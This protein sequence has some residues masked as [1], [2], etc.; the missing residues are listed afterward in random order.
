M[1]AEVCPFGLWPA[2]VGWCAGGDAAGG[3]RRLEPVGRHQR[4]HAAAV[5]V[6]APRHDA[7]VWPGLRRREAQRPSAPPCGP[8]PPCRARDPRF[9]LC[10]CAAAPHCSRVSRR[11]RL[12]LCPAHPRGQRAPVR[13]S[14][15][16]LPAVG[17]AL[18]VHLIDIEIHQWYG[19]IV[20][21]LVCLLATAGRRCWSEAHA[22]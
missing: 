8:L 22:E 17:S 18:R 13:L 5:Q 12:A 9:V 10:C 19:G 15:N 3:L 14:S 7:H 4:P 6:P 16:V 21:S 11:C 1:S 2:L 20:E